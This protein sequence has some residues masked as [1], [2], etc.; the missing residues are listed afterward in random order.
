MQFGRV[1]RLFQSVNFSVLEL[2]PTILNVL[3]VLFLFLILTQF[4][5]MN[6]SLIEAICRTNRGF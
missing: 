5:M 1:V 6:L 4:E 3:F 2:N